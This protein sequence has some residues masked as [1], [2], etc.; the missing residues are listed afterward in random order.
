[1]K[2]TSLFLL[3]LAS[4]NGFSDNKCLSLQNSKF[5]ETTCKLFQPFLSGWGHE[6]LLPNQIDWREENV[7][8]PVKNQGSCGSCWTF[9]STGAMEGAYALY[10]EKLES[11]SEQQ[12][13]DCVKKDFGCNGGEMIDAFEYVSEN[14]VCT[15]Q[16]DPYKATNENCVKCSSPVKFSGCKI[17]ERNNQVA[18]KEAV[19]IFG[20]ISVGIQ[21]DQP[22]FRYYKGGIIQDESCGTNVDHG[23]LIVGYGEESGIKYWL[24]KNSWG[25]NWGENGYVK[26]LREDTTNSLGICGIASSASFP[27]I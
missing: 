10:S 8:T 18:L 3:L 4:V 6:H 22:V 16:Q 9:S 5:N 2:I 14:P 25:E 20:P 24:V 12:L 11:F 23:V 17:I 27:Y 19:A 7:V 21:A 15:E 1:M 13:L 26:I